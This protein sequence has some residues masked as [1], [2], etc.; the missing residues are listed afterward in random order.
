ME[1]KD[2]TGIGEKTLAALAKHEISTIYDLLSYYPRTYREYLPRTSRTA[3]VGEWV[4]LVGTISRPASHHTA[5]TTTQLSTFQDPDGRLT[6]RWFNSP[7]MVRSVD[8]GATYLVRGQLTFFGSTRQIVNPELKIIPDPQ[9]TIHNIRS[10]LVP[11]YTSLGI[12]KSGNL[13]KIIM[14]ALDSAPALRETLSPEIRD[15]FNLVDLSTAL[16]YI[17]FPPTRSDL[18]S[19][20]H[21]LGFDELYALQLESQKN[22][23]LTKVKTKALVFTRADLDPWMSGLP[24]T[25]TNAQTQAIDTILS[26]LGK[27]LAM[28]RLLQGEVGSG[29]TLVAAA[30]SLATHLAGHQ[31]LVLAPTQILA[32]QLHRSLAGF[33]AERATVALVERGVT[34]DTT[35]DVVVG[36]QALLQD[37]HR[38]GNIGLVIV[39]EQHRFGVEQRLLLTKVSPAPHFLMMTATPIPRSLAMTLFS[40]LDIS[41]LDELPKNR[42]PIKTFYVTDNKRDQAYSW[43]RQEILT[44]HNQAFVVVPLIDEAEDEE[45]DAKKSIRLLETYLKTHLPGVVVDVMHGRM[46]PAEK[47]AHLQAFRDGYTEILVATS[48][49]EVGIDIPTA[50]IMVIEDAE[51]FGLSQLHQLRGRVGRGGEQGYC[52]LFVGAGSS[53]P[54]TQNRIKYFVR[55]TSGI[56]LAEYDLH[57]R[58]AGNLFGTAQHGFFS[59]R[60]A[61][62]YDAELL[63]QTAEAAKIQIL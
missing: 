16:H 22:R 37:K 10:T 1:L 59:L 63:R 33:L 35:A 29:K 51:R 8:P 49:V 14:S 62:L 48:M 60:F 9:S 25:P 2:V 42:L 45:G 12:L 30:A 21:R 27:P 58:G 38:F 36:T 56:K 47:T 57:S 61:S 18:E 3:G 20:I 5:H 11:I 13:R 46:K 17:H 24:F 43:I 15:Q 23:E 7:F 19:A 31:T 44:K 54:S 52:L 34:G 26:D 41:Y 28:H 50:N 55:E 39:D 40:G 53:R 32:E 6:L 4:S